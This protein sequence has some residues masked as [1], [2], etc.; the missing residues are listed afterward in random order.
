[1]G[2]TDYLVISTFSISACNTVCSETISDDPSTNDP[3]SSFLN[4]MKLHLQTTPW[5]LNISDL[6]QSFGINHSWMFV[7][8]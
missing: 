6:F 5:I 7:L 1:M 8:P 2:R 3:C 4:G